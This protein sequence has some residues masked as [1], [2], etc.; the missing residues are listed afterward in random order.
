MIVLLY[1]RVAR[2]PYDPWELCVTP[3]HFAE[4]LEV[5]R[6][7]RRMRLDQ[8]RTSRWRIRREEPAVAITFDDGYADNLHEAA[9]LLERFDTPATF[10]I[11]TGY[12]GSGREF[13]W[14]ELER[15][16]G[17]DGREEYFALYEKLRPLEDAARRERLDRMRAARGEPSGARDSHRVLTPEELCRLAAPGLFEIGAHTVTHPL[18]AALPASEQRR[19]LAESRA[20][21]QNLLGKEVASA[22]YPYGGSGHYTA[23]T[24]R[25][26]RELGY[27]RACTTAGRRVSRSDHPWELPRL[28]VTDMDG[29][30]F[31]RWLSQQ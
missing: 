8:V 25:L 18:L 29:E 13:W 19:E 3:E 26:A 24:V 20:W 7:W 28:N 27:R 4:H 10:F 30:T 14:D 22:S 23:G 16:L 6:R 15:I 9:R 5:L 2:T 12:V 17:E 31:E 11:S 1:H 21:L